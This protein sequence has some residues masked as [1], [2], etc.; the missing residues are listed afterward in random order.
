MPY[1]I[2]FRRDTSTN[3][4]SNNPVLA[5]GEPGL[6]TD[7][8]LLKMGNGTLPW[9][10]LPYYGVTGPNGQ[11]GPT[12]PVGPAGGPGPTGTTGPM[13]TDYATTGSNNFYGTQT[14]HGSIKVEDGLIMNPNEFGGTATVPSAYNASLVG[15]IT[16]TGTINVQGTG[17]LAIL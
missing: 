1:R 16:L 5:Q 14:V 9:L 17:V 13:P 8:G 7:T 2:L 10:S 15:P 6:E 11:L 4:A 12:G 3:W